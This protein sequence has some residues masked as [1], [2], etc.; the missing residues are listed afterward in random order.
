MGNWEHNHGHHTSRHWVSG[1]VLIGIGSIFLLD[2]WAYIDSGS[3][4]QYWP[5]IIALAGVGRMVDARSVNQATK[6]GFLIFFAFWLYANLQHLWGLNFFNSWPMILIALGLRHIIA[7][8]ATS[9]QKSSENSP[10]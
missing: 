8:V 3:W 1:L 6:G 4:I 10:S 5:F 9:Y 7:G 2:R